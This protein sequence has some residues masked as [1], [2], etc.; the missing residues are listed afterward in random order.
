MDSAPGHLLG[1]VPTRPEE[2][3]PAPSQDHSATPFPSGEP[4]RPLT[5]APAQSA[6][7]GVRWGCPESSGW[8]GILQPLRRHE[9]LRALLAQRVPGE[10]VEKPLSCSRQE[11]TQPAPKTSPE[12]P[13]SHG[14]H[15]SPCIPQ[16]VGH[17]AKA[18]QH[19]ENDPLQHGCMWGSTNCWVLELGDHREAQSTGDGRGQ[20]VLWSWQG[21]RR[22]LSQATAS[23]S[24]P[25]WMRPEQDSGTLPLDPCESKQTWAGSAA[26]TR[27]KPSMGRHGS[28]TWQMDGAPMCFTEHCAPKPG[29][30][31]GPEPPRHRRHMCAPPPPQPRAQC[32][33]YCT[34][35]GCAQARVGHAGAQGN[36]PL[37]RHLPLSPA[38]GA[39]TG[40]AL[41]GGGPGHTALLEPRAVGGIQG[42]GPLHGPVRGAPALRVRVAALLDADRRPRL[43]PQVLRGLERGGARQG[44]RQALPGRHRRLH[45]G[46]GCGLRAQ[47][48]AARRDSGCPAPGSR[49]MAPAGGG[50]GQGV[51]AAPSSAARR[52]PR[53][54]G[55]GA[56]RGGGGR[57]GPGGSMARAALG[58]ER[59]APHAPAEPAA[60]AAAAPPPATPRLGGAGG[61]AGARLPLRRSTEHLLPAPARSRAPRQR[62]PA[63]WPTPS[64]RAAHLGHDWGA[65]SCSPSLSP[66]PIE[67]PAGR[68]RGTPPTRRPGVH[69]PEPAAGPGRAHVACFPPAPRD[70]AGRA[71]GTPVPATTWAG[72]LPWGLFLCKSLPAQLPLARLGSVQGPSALMPPGLGGGHEHCRVQHGTLAWTPQVFTCPWVLEGP[73][74]ASVGPSQ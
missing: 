25:C 45:S 8:M 9:R 53:A 72:S 16:A 29:G 39:G 11:L 68:W 63:G 40:G 62:D 5:S 50:G 31:G 3:I 54:P 38:M 43:S 7:D 18:G 14:Q 57:P 59:R 73:G 2:T 64:P 1:F 21:L 19:W 27:P 69:G 4:H 13:V 6:C 49:C 15:A 71:L 65:R 44:Q 41:E 26:A 22:G 66:S 56:G 12:H 37:P 51:A 55:A 20:T 47:S 36:P 74:A 61:G 35:T 34:A 33:R 17:V 30:G 48:R 28:D 10:D 58:S 70:T 23:P 32:P 46:C 24:S 67:L 52:G 42:V 60:A